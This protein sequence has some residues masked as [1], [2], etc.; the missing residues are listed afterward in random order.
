M[1]EPFIQSDSNNDA[2]CKYNTRLIFKAALCWAFMFGFGETSF[3]LFADHLKAPLSFYGALIWLPAFIGPLVQIISANLLDRYHFR[4]KISY[5]CVYVQTA[6]F[7]PLIIIAFWSDSID[8]LIN[9]ETISLSHII[10]LFSL[11]VYSLSGNFATP[12]WQSLIGD[13]I[14]ENK[15]GSFFAKISKI[16]TFFS[17]ASSLLV[18]VLLL[19][20]GKYFPS[21]FKEISFIFAGCFIISFISRTYSGLL[22]KQMKEIPYQVNSSTIFTFWQFLKRAPESNFVKYVIFV[23]VLNCGINI[24]NPYCFPFWRDT[25]HYSQTMWV[26]LTSVGTITSILTFVAWGR[27]S[28]IFGHKSTIKYCSILLSIAPFGWLVSSNFYYLLCLQIVTMVFF[29]G[30]ALS[31]LNYIYEAASQPKRARCFAYFSVLTGIGTFIGTQIGLFISNNFT[32]DIF[33]I[34]F[35]SPFYWVLIISGLVRLLAC[36]GFLTTFKELRQVKPFQFS[37][38]WFNVLELKAVLGVNSSPNETPEEPKAK[39]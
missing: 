7:I 21:S 26:I 4:V 2:I 32:S 19:I 17:L 36:A 9:L 33:G 30:F 22:I 37:S 3:M 38:F 1:T 16:N 20:V 31:T 34:H 5:L 11:F 29:T 35:E 15:R 14:P 13:I 39:D 8:S 6:S 12:P 25:L 23:S 24:S 10:F 28:N 27:F 18:G